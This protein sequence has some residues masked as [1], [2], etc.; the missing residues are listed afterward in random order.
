MHRRGRTGDLQGCGV[1]QEGENDAEK[2]GGKEDEQAEP[3]EVGE[4]EIAAIMELVDQ[5]LTN[6][7]AV[8][9]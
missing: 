4:E 9:Q 3:E 5:D 6:L 2:E 8:Q 7:A 1:G